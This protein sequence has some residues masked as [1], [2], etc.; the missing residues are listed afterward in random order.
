MTTS[1]AA[2]LKK[3]LIGFGLAVVLTVIPF[4]A[5]WGGL[6]AGKANYLLIS[7][8]AMAQVIVHFYFFLHID[9]SKQKREDLYL[10]LFTV[11]ILLIMV[12]GTLWV[13]GDL[14]ARM[15]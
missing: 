13:M 8:C 5:V 10:I 6:F 4:A 3:Y 11:L 2:D 14:A 7:I 15:H 12:A 9:L 1:L